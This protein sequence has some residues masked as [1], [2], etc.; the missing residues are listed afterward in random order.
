M[1]VVGLMYCRLETAAV[2][3]TGYVGTRPEVS[4]IEERRLG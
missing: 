4:Q 3:V 1:K 2:W